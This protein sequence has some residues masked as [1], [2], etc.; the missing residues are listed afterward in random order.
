MVVAA[1]FFARLLEVISMPILTVQMSAE[2]L[3]RLDDL[4]R[5]THRTRSDLVR[6]ALTRLEIAQPDL[7]V[8]SLSAQERS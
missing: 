5:K 3:A 1:Y 7:A 6:A 8:I 2:D 4:A